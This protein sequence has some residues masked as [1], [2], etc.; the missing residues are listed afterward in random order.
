MC[1]AQGLG[2]V[3]PEEEEVCRALRPSSRVAQWSAA[4]HSSLPALLSCCVS[5]PLTLKLARPNP[6]RPGFYLSTR[7]RSSL[8]SHGGENTKQELTQEP[9]P[10]GSSSC[11]PK[12]VAGWRPEVAGSSSA[13]WELREARAETCL[14]SAGA[15]QLQWGHISSSGAQQWEQQVSDEAVLPSKQVLGVVFRCGCARRGSMMKPGGQRA[16]TC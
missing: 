3:G 9:W 12:V 8:C 15:H 11:T 10:F 5:A 16:A 1:G 13:G 4:S 14:G 2:D 6:G 7:P